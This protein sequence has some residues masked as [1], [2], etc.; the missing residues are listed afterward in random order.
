MNHHK[1]S[2]APYMG[3]YQ[4]L[5]R[6]PRDGFLK[7]VLGKGGVPLFFTT[8]LEAQE[9]ATRALEAYCDGHMRRDGETLS[10]GSCE[11]DRVFANFGKR[12]ARA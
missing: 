12:R 5:I 9:A 2:Y 11:R 1:A 10:T 8:A 6:L 4:A 7:P 3:G